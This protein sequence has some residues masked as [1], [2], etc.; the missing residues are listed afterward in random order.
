L[1]HTLPYR[2]VGA[3]VVATNGPAHSGEAD[4]APPSAKRRERLDADAASC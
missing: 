4:V 1:Q 3:V 2:W